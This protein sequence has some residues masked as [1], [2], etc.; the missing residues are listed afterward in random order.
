MRYVY[1]I[2]ASVPYKAGVDVD[3]SC[4]SNYFKAYDFL[5]SV[6]FEPIPGT[7][8]SSSPMLWHNGSTEAWIH[9]Y[10]VF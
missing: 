9:R 3:S 7:D 1:Q 8:S 2:K 5:L 4:F 10:P 6:G